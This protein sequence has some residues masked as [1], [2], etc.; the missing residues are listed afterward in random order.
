MG[1]YSD[2][3]DDDIRAEFNPDGIVYPPPHASSGW[4]FHDRE[5][6]L[7]VCGVASEEILGVCDSEAGLT[8][9]RFAYRGWCARCLY[10]RCIAGDD[11]NEDACEEACFDLD[12]APEDFYRE[13]A[14]SPLAIGQG[15]VQQ[16]YQEKTYDDAQEEQ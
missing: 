12:D 2:G 3:T 16:M 1:E 11:E 8:F 9:L 14:Y 5:S 6:F 4:S 13:L 10:Y 7:E 15:I